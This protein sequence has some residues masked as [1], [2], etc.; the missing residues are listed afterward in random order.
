MT[1]PDARRHPRSMEWE[2]E[3]GSNLRKYRLVAEN[4]NLRASL[5]L[6]HPTGTGGV[7][8][9]THTFAIAPTTQFQRILFDRVEQRISLTYE[10][11]SGEVFTGQLKSSDLRFDWDYTRSHAV[12]AL[13]RGAVGPVFLKIAVEVDPILP[14]GWDGKLPA[15]VIH[16]TSAR[17]NEKRAAAVTPGLR[18]L[19]VDLG[20]RNFASCSVLELRD[21]PPAP[22]KLAYRV[23]A[24]AGGLWAVHERSFVLHLPGEVPDPQ[25][26][27]WRAAAATELQTLRRGLNRYKR[28]YQSG[29]EGTPEGRQQR[30]AELQEALREVGWP[31]EER[32]LESLAPCVPLTAPEW[33]TRVDLAVRE[34]RQ[35]FGRIVRDWRRRSRAGDKVFGKSVWAIEYLTKVRLFL[36]S[37]SLSGE[38][39]GDIRRLDR[40]RRGTFAARLLNHIN[41]IKEDRLKT[42]ADLIVQAARGYLRGD[43]GEWRQ[44]YTPCHAVLFEDLARYRMKSDRPRR[45]NSQLM[46]WAHRQIPEEVKMQGEVYGINLCHTGAAFSS[47][48]HAATNTP[49]IR[50]HPVTVEDL[51]NEFFRQYVERENPGIAWERLHPGDLI[52]FSSGELFAYLTGTGKL[53][54]HADINAAQNLQRRFWTRHAEPFRLP[55]RRM[56]VNGAE[57]WLPYRL[58]KR[59]LG[60]LGGYG[61]LIPTGHE[62]GSCRWSDLTPAQWR[63]YGGELRKGEPALDDVDAV[64]EMTEDLL[65]QSG[66]VVVFFRDPSGVVLPKGL[67]YPAKFF[68]SRVK[69]QTTQAL[70]PVAFSEKH[71]NVDT[72][73]LQ[74]LRSSVD[75]LR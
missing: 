51:S 64:E 57:R 72:E 59:L 46:L 10:N 71:D 2:P 6:L 35:E 28:L 31:F 49:G 41:G 53:I 36:V 40:D 7:T 43:T 50:C 44:Q 63:N 27:A 1:L 17:G 42:G 61:L 12:A 4:G 39:F 32:L 70:L 22:G 25:G 37:W 56:K 3:G 5:P 30:V 33:A 9:V 20:L 73:A 75:V 14:P 16:F 29:H 45:E 24:A 68:W 15:A 47:R 54:I 69:T 74:A 38:R 67:W 65:E 60:G 55:A 58:G 26:E 11:Q 23:E 66:E 13:E 34:F 48:Y 8:E 19:S 52:P 18:V 62:S 21:L